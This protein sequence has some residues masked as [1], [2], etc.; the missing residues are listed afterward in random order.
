MR[1][2]LPGPVRALAVGD[3]PDKL[4]SMM[5]VDALPAC[6][7]WPSRPDCPWHGMRADG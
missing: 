3:W 4:L 6:N 2:A 5:T 1:F 7:R